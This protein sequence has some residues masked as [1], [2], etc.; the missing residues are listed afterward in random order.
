MLLQSSTAG[1]ELGLAC[2]LCPPLL[3]CHRVRGEVD[4]AA[5]LKGERH[6]WS[7]R[8]GSEVLMRKKHCRIEI[9]T[10]RQFQLSLVVVKA[11]RD[12]LESKGRGTKQ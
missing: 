4:R 9:E 1:K 10:V 6:F 2:T 5:V 12:V 8:R 3:G 11:C 7:L